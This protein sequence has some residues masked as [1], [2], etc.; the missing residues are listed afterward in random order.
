MCRVDSYKAMYKN[1][2]GTYNLQTLDGTYRTNREEREI[3]T[4]E[5]N[6]VN[7]LINHIEDSIK[8]LESQLGNSKEILHSFKQKY[9]L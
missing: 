2:N 7:A 9:S 3:Y 4:I 6:A 1:I 5:V 8:E